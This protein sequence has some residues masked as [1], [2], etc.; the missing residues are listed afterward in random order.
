MFETVSADDL[1]SEPTERP[2]EP[3]QVIPMTVVWFAPGLK[4][5]QSS[6]LTTVISVSVTNVDAPMSKPR[7]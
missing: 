1:P 2:W 3:V 6:S 5:T 7:S 4:A